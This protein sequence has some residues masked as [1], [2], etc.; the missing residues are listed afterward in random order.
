[1]TMTQRPQFPATVL[2]AAAVLFAQGGTRADDK[3]GEPAVLGTG[4]AVHCVVFSPDGKTLASSDDDG[5]ITLWDVATRKVRT[6]MRLPAKF[7]RALAYSP[8]GKTL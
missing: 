3:Q 2:A 1:M 4:A 6:S 8:D 5:V 7:V